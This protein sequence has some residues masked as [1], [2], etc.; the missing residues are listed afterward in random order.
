MLVNPWSMVLSLYSAFTNRQSN[1]YSC[2]YIYGLCGCLFHFQQSNILL[3]TEFREREISWISMHLF[4][5]VVYRTK[6][7]FFFTVRIKYK[8]RKEMWK[9]ADKHLLFPVNAFWIFFSHKS[10]NIKWFHLDI[11]SNCW[12]LSW[13]AR[14]NI[15]C[16]RTLTLTQSGTPVAPKLWRDEKNQGKK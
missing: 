4:N 11:F 10:P 2:N 12:S 13:I 14:G 1:G 8:G 9:T 16:S 5:F 7:I 15:H 6:S 3:S